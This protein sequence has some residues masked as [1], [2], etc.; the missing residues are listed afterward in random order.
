[1]NDWECCL[2]LA[3]QGWIEY[4]CS[5]L[6]YRDKTKGKAFLYFH[7]NPS[8]MLAFALD[9]NTQHEGQLCMTM[10]HLCIRTRAMLA[11]ATPAAPQKRRPG[12]SVPVAWLNIYSADAGSQVLPIHLLTYCLPPRATLQYLVFPAPAFTMH[13]SSQSLSFYLPDKSSTRDTGCFLGNC[14]GWL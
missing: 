3:L 2:T 11:Q 1:M 10:S 14:S 13:C 9:G 4:G 12:P 5:H 7:K 6:P 8:I